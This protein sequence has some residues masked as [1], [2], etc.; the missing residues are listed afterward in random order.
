VAL[1]LGVGAFALPG[2]DRSD[3]RAQP[4]TA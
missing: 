2:R 4:A 3:V 1:V